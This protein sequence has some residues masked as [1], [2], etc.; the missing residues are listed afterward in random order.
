MKRIII[1]AIVLMMV[2]IACEGFWDCPDKNEFTSEDSGDEENDEEETEDFP[3][4]AVYKPE[5]GEIGWTG[6]NFS[7]W[8]GVW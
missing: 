1:L 6:D 2:L 3:S 8:G 5:T 7:G 4:R